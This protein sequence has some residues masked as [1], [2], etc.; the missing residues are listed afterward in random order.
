MCAHYER[1]QRTGKVQ[2]RCFQLGV[3]GETWNTLGNGGQEG[4]RPSVGP[5][6]WHL[7]GVPEGW[8]N[9][10]RGVESKG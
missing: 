5:A 6:Q 10:R 8:F 2:S 1:P 4:V 3:E 7:L 9:G